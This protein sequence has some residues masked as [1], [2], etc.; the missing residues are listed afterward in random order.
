MRWGL[1]DLDPAN[2]V[3]GCLTTQDPM[4]LVPGTHRPYDSYSMDHMLGA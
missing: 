1:T 4:N 2:H 3:L